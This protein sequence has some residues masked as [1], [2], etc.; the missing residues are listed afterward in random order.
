MRIHLSRLCVPLLGATL[1]FFQSAH[2]AS[3]WD[4]KAPVDYVLSVETDRENALYKQGE[5]V[6]FN[7]ELQHN[8]K[9]AATEEI[10]WTT[11][12]DG[13]AP[14]LTG[15]LT[16]KD[17]RGVITGTLKEPGFLQCKVT[18]KGVKPEL[19]ALSAGGFD[20]Y[21]IKPSMPAPSDFD[22]F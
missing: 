16:L 3:S 22:A 6:T 13:V 4:G 9:P 12:K 19:T 2:A 5:T 14:I 15:K 1:L 17:G 10:E 20:L 7:V 18:F 21:S 8:Q 11:S